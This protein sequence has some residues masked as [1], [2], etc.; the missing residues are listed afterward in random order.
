MLFR[1]RGEGRPAPDWGRVPRFEGVRT[2]HHHEKEAPSTTVTLATIAP[3]SKEPDTAATRLKYLPRSLAHAILNRRLSIL[4]RRES[5]P[6]VSGSAGVGEGFGFYRQSAVTISCRAE[7]WR[8]ALGVG[9]QELRRALE[10]GFQPAELTEAR[11]GPTLQPDDLLDF[12][13]LLE[14]GD[15]FAGLEDMVRRSPSA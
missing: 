6:F 7:Q 15:W 14:S 3:Y 12:H 1:S 8:D 4:A 5:A 13:L 9:E 11:T 2:F 10:H